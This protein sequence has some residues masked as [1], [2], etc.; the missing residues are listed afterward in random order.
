MCVHIHTH[1]H[2]FVWQKS[3]CYKLLH[4]VLFGKN[5]EEN[6][7]A[8]KKRWKTRYWWYIILYSIKIYWNE[9]KASFMK[10]I[11]CVSTVLGI[12]QSSIRLKNNPVRW[13]LLFHFLDQRNYKLCT[14]A[15]F[16]WWSW[17]WNSGVLDSF[18]HIALS[19]LPYPFNI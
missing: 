3:S 1:V 14:S 5:M 13:I 19:P 17:N 12:L 18:Q 9:G 16:T 2:T 6:L 10:H 7:M 4:M 15:I 8:F 11:P